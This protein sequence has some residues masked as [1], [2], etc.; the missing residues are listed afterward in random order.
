[1]ANWNELA[2]ALADYTVSC[3][4]NVRLRKMQRDW[5]RILHFI[6]SDT[7]VTFSMEVDH[8]EILSTPE[9][10]VGTPDIVVTTES[11]TFCDMFWGDLNPVQKYLRGVIKVKG[12]QEDVMRLDA[13]SYVIWPDS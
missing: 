12:S 11:E 9:G 13:I 8:G 10:H 1:M 4:E 5:S 6:C 3:N 2:E 7:G